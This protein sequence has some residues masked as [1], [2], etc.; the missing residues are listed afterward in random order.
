MIKTILTIYFV[1]AMIYFI[2]N[3]SAYCVGV[4]RQTSVYK[5]GIT[6]D[7]IFDEMVTTQG[8]SEVKAG[9]K[10]IGLSFACGMIWPFMIYMLYKYWD[11]L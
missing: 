3:V 10:I 7:E 4:F 6:P 8:G 5:S 11:W 1:I 9:I 2:L